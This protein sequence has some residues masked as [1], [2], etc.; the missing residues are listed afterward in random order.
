MLAAASLNYTVAAAAVEKYA[1]MHICNQVT[2][3][4]SDSDA[5]SSACKIAQGAAIGKPQDL[6]WSY[7][8]T[9]TV[10]ADKLK[11][12]ERT[13]LSANK[14]AH[15]ILRT[16][17]GC[18]KTLLSSTVKVGVGHLEECSKVKHKY[19]GMVSALEADK[20]REHAKKGV[21]SCLKR[22]SGPQTTLD[23]SFLPVP[24]QPERHGIMKA[25]LDMLIMCN[26]H[27]A[28]RVVDSPW[29]KRFCRYLRAGFVPA[30]QFQWLFTLALHCF[31]LH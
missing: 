26:M 20:L 7:F 9:V 14:R 28:F 6:C 30:C 4:M 17:I 5:N 1:C 16:C 10:A 31:L 19:P 22:Q 27:M 15:R 3:A 29:F 24:N 18:G 12:G 2:S 23:D 8:S 21:P 25:M 11:E 13:V